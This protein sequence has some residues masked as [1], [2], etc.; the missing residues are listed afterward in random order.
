MRGIKWLFFW[1]ATLHLRYMARKTVVACRRAGMLTI[2]LLDAVVL[3]LAS[4]VLYAATAAY[5]HAS[6]SAVRL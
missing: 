4:A 2:M 1:N 3:L 6:R 5:V